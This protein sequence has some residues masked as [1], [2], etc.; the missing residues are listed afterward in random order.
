VRRWRLPGGWRR[1]PAAVRRAV[2]VRAG[3]DP[4]PAAALM[5][6]QRVHTP[7]ESGRLWGEDG[8][9]KGPGPATASAGGP[10]R[11]AV[12]GLEPPSVSRRP[13]GARRRLSGRP[14]GNSGWRASGLRAPIAAPPLV[15]GRRRLA[16]GSHAAHA[17]RP[18]GASD[19]GAG[20]LHARGDGRGG[21]A[22]GARRMSARGRRAQRCGRSRGSASW[23]IAWRAA[24]DAF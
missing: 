16:C 6:S 9:G 19:P 21:G 5:A 24:S 2:R 8:G 15:G 10:A 11:A 18:R 4:E 23:G 14:R 1:G 13:G 22:S 3:R 17:A 20:L 7:A 12:V